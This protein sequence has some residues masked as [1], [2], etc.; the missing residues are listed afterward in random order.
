MS[1]QGGET[2]KTCADRLIKGL[3]NNGEDKNWTTG[4]GSSD[5]IQKNRVITEKKTDSKTKQQLRE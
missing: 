1:L 4:E 2:F 3:G 5:A